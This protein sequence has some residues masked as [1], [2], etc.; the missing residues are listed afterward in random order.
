M[1]ETQGILEYQLTI[2][3][4]GIILGRYH[5]N[6]FPLQSTITVGMVIGFK[7]ILPVGGWTGF[8]VALALSLYSSASQG[9]RTEAEPGEELF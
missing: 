4:G 7:F 9:T 6:I 8:I 1:L 3:W 5:A 2:L